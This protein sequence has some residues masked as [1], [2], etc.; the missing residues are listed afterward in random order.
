MSARKVEQ[1]SDDTEMM[2]AGIEAVTSSAM[3]PVN[4]LISSLFGPAARE[5]GLMLQDRIKVYRKERQFRLYIRT[6]EKLKALGVTPQRVPLKLLFPIIENA[7]VEEDDDLQDR[8]ASLLANAANPANADGIPASFVNILRELSPRQAK[9]LDALYDYAQKR[10][11]LE[12]DRTLE[13]IGFSHLDF[14][15]VFSEIGLARYPTS[16]HYSAAEWRREDVKADRAEREVAL[17]VFHRHRIM[18]EVYDLGEERFT[19]QPRQPE[20]DSE[21]HFTALG[22][23]FVATCRPPKPQGAE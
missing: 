6:M 18:V 12:L 17:D 7:S 4:D 22:A 19:I 21:V 8:W 11:D 16:Q 10:S 14:V 1:V 5:A 15:R 9:Y 2:K 20:L 3:K 23:Q 13:S